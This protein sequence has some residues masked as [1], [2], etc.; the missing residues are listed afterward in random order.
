M[1]DDRSFVIIGAGL[2]GAEAADTLRAEGFA[3]RVVLLGEERVRPYDRV[4]LSKQYLRSEPG[5]HQLFVHDEDYYGAH[6]I[7]LRLG[8]RAA[9][10]DVD[11]QQVVLESGERLDYDQLLLTTGSL[12][13]KLRLPGADLQGVHYLR[14]LSDAD[15]LRDAITAAH[16]VVV[17]GAGFIGCEV[18]ASARQLGKE[19][20]LVDVAPL[21]IEHALGREI[22]EF[23]RQVHADHGVDLHL[24]VGVSA[25][26]G[27]S[28]VEG[29]ELSDGQVLAADVV[30]IGV[31]VQ[32]RVEL[33]RSAGIT[34]DNGIATDEHLATNVPGIFAAGDV[35]NAR[36]PVLG[37]GL[38]LE[39]WS[40]AL[41]QGPV[42]ARNML[43]ME[44]VYDRVPFF[45]TDQYDVWME[46]TGYAADG[47]ELV[48]R[49]DLVAGEF[50]AFWL[51]DDRLI[52]GMNVN[53]KGVPDTIAAL[54]ASGEA[55]DRAALADPS[56]DLAGLLPSK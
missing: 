9:A 4:P 18:A 53:I 26:R 32:P 14:R 12:L 29:V 45:F 36:H 33:A 17:V 42:A 34:V 37:T 55:L 21:P 22:G 2:A 46:Y 35:A 10:I 7:E 44:V 15:R 23:Y 13:R 40:A 25:F 41:E 6:D 50:I 8:T 28:T 54:V 11:G 52:A 51:R 3:G 43:G 24:G 56:V 19:V 38:R 39:H 5:G 30:V 16:R 1:S 27:A 47:A 31:G 49:G 20:A 48:I